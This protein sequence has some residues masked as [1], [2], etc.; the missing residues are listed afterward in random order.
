MAFVLENEQM[1]LECVARAGEIQHFFDK[2][3]NVE[4]M[5]QGD[6]GWSGKNPTLFPII[7]ST[8]TGSYEIDGKTYSMKNHG[9]IRYADLDGK[10]T[11]D[12]IVFTYDSNDDTR[13]QY[14]FD[15]HYEMKYWLEDKKLHIDYTVVNT[16][17]KEMPFTFG[18]HPAF[19]VPQFEGEKFEDYSIDY[20]YEEVATQMVFDPK[21]E[22]PVEYP[23]VEFKSWNLNR[24]DIDKYA[25]IVYKDLKSTYVTLS[26]KGEGR[27]RV[28]FPDFPLLA[29]W[30]HPSRSN[31]ICI[32]PWYGHADFE[33]VDVPFEKREGTMML[34]PGETFKTNYIIEAL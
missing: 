29:I 8:H 2:E 21:M 1:R 28:H 33:K 13:A 3:K 5:Y 25:T 20:E 22:K 16:G 26:C 11:D 27:V 7:G 24:E 31:F 9:L 32:E 19:R 14:P 18:L 12:A 23:T 4:L 10:V 30:S 34:K 15:F 6:E 17:D